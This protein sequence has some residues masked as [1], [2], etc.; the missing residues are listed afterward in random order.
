MPIWSAEIK[1]LEKL[2]ESFRGQLPDLEKELGRLILAD[3]ENMSLLYSRR[4]L[5]VIV[6]DLCECELKRPRKT[7]PLKGI[8]DKLN[9]EE[10]VPSNII[11][12]MDHLNSLSAYGA[13]PKDFD[14]EQV[15]PVLNNLNIIIKWYL[16]YKG[17]DIKVKEEKIHPSAEPLKRVK[18]EVRIIG[19]EKSY[20]LPKRKILYGLL[21]TAILF[22][23]AL[24]VYQK[25]FKKDTLERLRSLG[26]RISVAVMPFQNMTN[27]TIWNVWQDGIQDI[28]ITYLSNSPEELKV[29]QPEAI[30]NLI[31]SKKLVN[32]A[33]LTPSIASKISQKLEANIFVYGSIIKAGSTLR[34]NAQLIDTNTEESFKSFEVEGPAREESIFQIT[35]SLKQ[36]VKNYLILSVLEKDVPTPY[37]FSNITDS[38]EAFRDFIYGN[39]FLYNRD[40]PTAIDWYLKSLAADS[41]FDYAA[42]Y[43]SVAYRLLGSYEQG[44][45]WILDIYERRDQMPLNI[46]TIVDWTYA[47]YFETPHEQ[48]KY[49][50]QYLEI[51]DQNAFLYWLLGN[52]YSD[53]FQFDKAIPAY[54]KSLELYEKWE[55]KPSWSYNYTRLGIAY[56]ATNQFRKEKKLYE[57]AERDFPGDF[58]LLYWQAV[59]ALYE[60]RTKQA[61]NYIGKYV[62]AQKERSATDAAIANNLAGIYE[63][64][65]MLDEAEEYYR[66]ALS[67]EPE[68][69]LRLNNL[70]WFLIDND[71]NID[72]GI[73]LINRALKL[74]PD[75]YYMVDTKG[76]GLYKQ[77]KYQ[78]ALKL[79]QKSW[80][81]Y[82][83][84]DHEAFLHLE[85]AKKVVAN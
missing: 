75:V 21:I 52:A 36:M 49:L 59:L 71:R 68:N 51:D 33:S 53:L 39:K 32:Y 64:A 31:R 66:K 10:K 16:K 7:E 44:K 17:G 38:P 58:A 26:E 25:V 12:S 47:R 76:W 69:P 85:A 79:L 15:K 48:I 18:Q 81:L 30:S 82:P 60:G 50:K 6:T 35:D 29:K 84:Y 41:T 46:R 63:E 55:I 56:H 22:A 5:E 70:A 14:P 1:E 9:K 83:I 73:E 37:G 80:D 74:S 3:D 24:I 42:S 54:E 40:Y 20:R 65:K 4:C 57:K 77:G 45:K 61:D 13:H 19:Q 67:L 27:D 34:L 11:T 28:L 72:E 78:E 23:A 62:S 2:Y 43:L 8:I